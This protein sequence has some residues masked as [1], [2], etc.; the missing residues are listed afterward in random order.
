MIKPTQIKYLPPEEAEKYVN[1]Q[2][3]LFGSDI[4]YFT[5]VPSQDPQYPAE[6]GWEDVLYYTNR[7]K[8]HQIEHDP[9]YQYVYIFK[10]K[11]MPGLIKIGYTDK[12]P[13]KRAQGVSK[14]T[15]VPVEFETVF[16][17][18]CFNVKVNIFKEV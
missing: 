5:Y 2:D 11:A 6:E 9:S 1:K 15:G 3:D 14:A 13:D 8:E 18:P 7:L 17:F 4:W 10:N 12:E 16:Y